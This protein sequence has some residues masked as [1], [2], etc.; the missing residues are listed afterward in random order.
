MGVVQ[1]NPTALYEDN[2]ACRM[3]S[4]NPVQKERSKHI[5][6]RIHA[7]RERVASGDV[8]VLDCA[9]ADMVADSLTKNLPRIAFRRC[10]DVQMGKSTHNAPRPVSLSPQA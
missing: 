5:D 1:R 4:E 6:F 9:S 3:M 8:K 2:R 10:V 7:L